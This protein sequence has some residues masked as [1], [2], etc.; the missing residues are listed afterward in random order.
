[1]C[2]WIVE[3]SVGAVACQTND[4]SGKWSYYAVTPDRPLISLL[5]WQ[6]EAV[7][8]KQSFIKS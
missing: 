1:M 6:T 2:A 8:M 7:D 3:W 4:S 5:L